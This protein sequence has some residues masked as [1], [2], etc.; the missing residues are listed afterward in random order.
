MSR[1]FAVILIEIIFKLLTGEVVQF[2]GI[3]IPKCLFVLVGHFKERKIYL[4]SL[5]DKG[6]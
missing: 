6:I 3:E 5:F 2:L 4:V 1:L